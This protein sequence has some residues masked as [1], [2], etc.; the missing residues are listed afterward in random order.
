MGASCLLPCSEVY[1]DLLEMV[2]IALMA[3]FQPF[4][5]TRDDGVCQ[6][7]LVAIHLNGLFMSA[8][9]GGRRL[10]AMLRFITVDNVG[11]HFEVSDC[12]CG[13][14]VSVE[15]LG[16]NRVD[17]TAKND[18]GLLTPPSH[19]TGVCQACGTIRPEYPRC[20]VS[21]DG[22]LPSPLRRT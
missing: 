20:H 19:C 18:V 17:A 15:N 2:C 12:A 3:V 1:I 11:R 13:R 5:Y 21:V 4:L 9:D 8:S 10:R 22:L 14:I 16:G 6:P 7:R